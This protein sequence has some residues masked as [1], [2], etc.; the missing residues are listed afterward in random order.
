MPNT[1]DQT[2][3][4]G[5]GDDR[6]AQRIGVI[7][8]GGTV[9]VCIVAV[10]LLEFHHSTESTTQAI[11]ALSA[12]G[13]AAVGGIAGMLTFS[14]SH[15]S[16]ISPPTPVQAAPSITLDP[17]H[18]AAGTSFQVNGSGFAPGE[19]VAIQFDST[20]L[21]GATANSSGNIAQNQIVPAAAT[22]GAHSI[23]ATG[24]LNAN[25]ARTQITVS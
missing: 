5:S 17:D 1:G 8:L 10:V 4:N 12:L 21:A 16:Q 19:A 7:L 24:A 23:T 11:T 20:P 13:S 14:R 6:L 2:S 25:T 18:G 3:D 9:L 22:S 15:A